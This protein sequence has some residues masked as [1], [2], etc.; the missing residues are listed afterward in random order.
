MGVTPHPKSSAEGPRK[1]YSY[2]STHP[3]GVRG[4]YKGKNLPTYL[5]ICVPKFDLHSYLPKH[6]Y[7]LRRGMTNSGMSLQEF[8][9][10]GE[11]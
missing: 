5:N 6:Y 9:E 1:E 2:T 7:C 4:L 10:F 11:M 3:K 8:K